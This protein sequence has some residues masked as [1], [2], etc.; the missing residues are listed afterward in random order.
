MRND[1]SY[2]C[3][4]LG[5]LLNNAVAA[6]LNLEDKAVP[7][8]RLRRLREYS[9][10]L[11]EPLLEHLKDQTYEE[12][13]ITYPAPLAA[14]ELVSILQSAALYTHMLYVVGSEKLPQSKVAESLFKKSL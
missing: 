2:T 7:E 5:V 4:E 8:A 3:K 6:S 9:Q 11:L 14:H 13:G 10:A 12:E 1:K